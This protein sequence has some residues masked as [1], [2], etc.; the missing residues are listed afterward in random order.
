MRRKAPLQEVD[1]LALP[2][3]TRVGPWRVTGFRGRGSYGTLYRV[4]RVGHEQKWK[5]SSR[6][7]GVRSRGARPSRRARRSKWL[8]RAAAQGAKRSC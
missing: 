6:N 3:G 1:P 2:V 4:E 7:A 8:D 5:R